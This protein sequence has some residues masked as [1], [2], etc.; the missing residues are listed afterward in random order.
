[1]IYAVKDKATYVKRLFVRRY[2]Q[3]SGH[4][5]L[6]FYFSDI[7]LKTFS[8]IY[9][10]QIASFH[11]TAKLTLKE[12]GSNTHSS[13]ASKSIPAEAPSHQKSSPDPS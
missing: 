12:Y 1:M 2:L 8:T 4:Q 9:P 13:Q 10:K 7:F 5:D 11:R 6:S 3:E